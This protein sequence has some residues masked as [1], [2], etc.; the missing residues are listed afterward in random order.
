MNRKGKYS[1][2]IYDFSIW[3][4][5]Y[6]DKNSLKYVWFVYQYHHKWISKQINDLF[7][8]IKR[9]NQK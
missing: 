3:N 7:E 9:N 6:W 2:L 4:I 5:L 1:M 8:L